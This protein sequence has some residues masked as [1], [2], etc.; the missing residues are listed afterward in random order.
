MAS[1]FRQWHPRI[2]QV[3]S[4]PHLGM[5]LELGSVYTTAELELRCASPKRREQLHAKLML[6]LPFGSLIGAGGL[7]DYVMNVRNRALIKPFI[8]DCECSFARIKCNYSTPTPSLACAVN[9]Q[10]R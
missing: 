6:G 4:Y 8:P 2:S 3:L 10:T 7:V 9:L 1:G 5:G